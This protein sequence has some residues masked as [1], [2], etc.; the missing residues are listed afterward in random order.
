[1]YS[2]TCSTVRPAATSCFVE[3]MSTP[4][5]H[6]KRMGG[7]EMRR[8]TSLAPARRSA[9]MI[10]RDVVPRTMVSSTATTRLPRSERGSGFSF[11]TTPASRSDWSG[12]MNVRLM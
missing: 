9:S 6:G 5:K 11:S 10:R 2:R 4:M 8:W 12:W 7:L 1:M 3:P